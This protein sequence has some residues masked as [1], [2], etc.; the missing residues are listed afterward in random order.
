MPTFQRN[1]LSPSSRAE[2]TTQGNREPTVMFQGGTWVDSGLREGSGPFQGSLEC[3]VFLFGA[4]SLLVCI[5]VP[6]S[7]PLMTPFRQPLPF[8]SYIS[9]LFPCLVTSAL[10]DGDNMFLQNIGIDQTYQHGIKTQ[11]LKK[12]DNH[13]ENLK[14]HLNCARSNLSHHDYTFYSILA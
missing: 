6:Y 9:P 12:H 5:A 11:K 13:R 7:F 10:E 8:W 4:G 14:S 2:V 1:I 3:A